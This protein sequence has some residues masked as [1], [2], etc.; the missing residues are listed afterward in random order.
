MNDSV[1]PVATVDGAA[2]SDYFTYSTSAADF[3]TAASGSYNGPFTIDG[4]TYQRG[5]KMDSNGYVTFTTSST[6]TTTLRF[7]FARRKSADTTA[8]IQLV[9][10]GGEAVVFDTPYDTYADSGVITLAAGTEY[11]IKRKDREQAVILVTVTE[12]E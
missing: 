5:F 4:T 1:S 9:P 10:T 6:Y 3:R 2:G 11:T 7:W 8:Q 12:S